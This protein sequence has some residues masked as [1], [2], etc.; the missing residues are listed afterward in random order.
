MSSARLECLL[1]CHGV[2]PAGACRRFDADSDLGVPAEGY[3]HEDFEGLHQPPG[4]IDY[5]TAYPAFL[6]TKLPL[7]PWHWCMLPQR[8]EFWANALKTIRGCPEVTS[9]ELAIILRR[10]HE[11]VS[12]AQLRDGRAGTAP[13]AY[14]YHNGGI[15]MLRC[16]LIAAC[17]LD[18]F[19]A[20][21]AWR[22]ESAA[23]F[24]DY[25]NVEFYPTAS[26]RRSPSA[27]RPVARSTCWS[28]P[29]SFATSPMCRPQRHGW[30]P[31]RRPFPHCA[32]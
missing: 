18:D 6:E 23:A 1:C 28:L 27:I 22:S 10:M 29:S 19:H 4:P 3:G 15:D 9:E 7:Q 20:A 17:L 2:F 12:F 13:W 24:V 21:R 14:T 8:L 30:R 32:S 31:R 26:A 11:E 16:T 25:L 5:A